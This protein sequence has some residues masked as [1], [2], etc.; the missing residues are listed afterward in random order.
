MKL[1][2]VSINRPVFAIMMSVALITLGIFS[3]RTLGVDLMPKVDQPT[4]QVNV[5][6]QGAS[7]EEVESTASKPLEE[8]INTING[9]DELTTNS[10]QGN[11]SA[12]ITF[13]LE[14][15]MDSAIQDV[16]DKVAPLTQRLPRDTPAPRVTKYDPD[17]QPIL[18]LAISGGRDPKELTEIVDRR[19][20]Q[21]LE[22]INGVGG[23]QFFG[24]R[25]RQ[26]QLLLDGDR[27]TA[28]GLTADQVRSAVERQ[29][30]EIPGG[31]FVAGESE[32]NL[33]TMGRLTAV[34][35]FDRIILSQ[36]NGSVITLGD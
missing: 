27:L 12:R 13:N 6:L 36:Q 28:Y 19:I 14:R 20:K 2:E 8:A 33:R 29:N 11:V 1:A 16:R 15:D 26:I 35:D 4:V 21:A 23:L 22:T 24:D 30:V 17:S 31:N 10:N 32:I 25:R 7:P 18:A 5:Q 34:T 3:Y 9:I